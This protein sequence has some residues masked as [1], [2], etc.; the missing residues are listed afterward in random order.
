MPGEKMAGKWQERA[1]NL[2][3]FRCSSRPANESRASETFCGLT[4]L[5]SVNGLSVPREIG[6]D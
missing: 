5:G 2:P 1:G 6:R 4:R 3:A